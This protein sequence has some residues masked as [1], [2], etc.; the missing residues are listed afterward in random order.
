ATGRQESW[1]D[2]GANLAEGYIDTTVVRGE[3]PKALV[4]MNYHGPFAYESSRRYQ[5]YSLLSALRIRLREA[6][7]EDKGGVYGVSV[8]GVALPYPEPNY[9]IT[10]SFNSEPARTQEL[11][12]TAKQVIDTLQNQAVDEEILQKVKETQRQSRIKSLKENGFWLGQVS[13][14]LKY[15][16]GLE[17]ILME[18]YEPY[19]EG[20]AAGDIQEA[21]QRYLREDNFIQVVLMP[22]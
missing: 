2:V 19:I 1:K 8:S 20:L 10:I 13:T 22:E 14:R 17:G 3:A 16:I 21:A 4:E 12:A 6:L 11:I 9:R 5:F 7:R 15:G 18:R